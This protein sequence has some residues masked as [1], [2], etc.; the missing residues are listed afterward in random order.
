MVAKSSGATAIF[1]SS[2]TVSCSDEVPNSINSFQFEQPLMESK[3][4]T[5]F[6]DFT[7]SFIAITLS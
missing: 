1:L 3:L 7:L 5:F 2:R 6:N 4:Y